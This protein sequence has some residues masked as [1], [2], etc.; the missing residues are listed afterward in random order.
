MMGLVRFEIRNA[1][2]LCV[3]IS[4]EVFRVQRLIPMVAQKVY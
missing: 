2:A 1:A 3:D 4:D